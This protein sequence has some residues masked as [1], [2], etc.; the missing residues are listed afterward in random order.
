MI[1]SENDIKYAAFIITYNRSGIIADTIDQILKQSLPPQKILVIDNS[2]NKETE[3]IIIDLKNPVLEYYHVGYNSGP[4]GAAYIGLKEL[5]GQNFDWLFWVDD[6]NPPAE[7]NLIEKIF[8]ILPYINV[9]DC[10]QLG[11][12]GHRFNKWTGEIDRL[13]NDELD[14]NVIEVDTIGGGQCKIISSKVARQGIFPEKKLFFGF[15]ELDID[16]KIKNAG[17]KSYVSGKLLYEA[18]K[19]ANRLNFIKNSAVSL[20]ENVLS[21]HYYS[22][23]NLLSIFSYNYYITA[24]LYL[25]IKKILAIILA[26]KQGPR[27][28]FKYSKIVFLAYYH[29]LKGKY[30]KIDLNL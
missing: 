10:G 22:I 2:D 26:F 9:E 25:S 27:A 20:D 6:D 28:G 17:F 23:R 29:F 18:R 21:R 3:K 1:Q 14:K 7:N 15:E 19:D 30:G 4:S 24:L 13:K 11:L 5:A 8:D 16:I 12:V